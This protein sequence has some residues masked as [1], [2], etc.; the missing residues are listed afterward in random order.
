[1]LVHSA[2]AFDQIDLAHLDADS[3]RRVQATNVESALWL[4]QDFTPGMVERGFGRII[5]VISDT[6]WSPPGPEMLPYVASKGA[7][8]GVMRTL[9]VALGGHGIAVS[10]VAPGLTDTTAS[11][12][13]NTDSDFDAVVDRQALKRRLTP[14]DTASAVAYLASDGGAAMTGQILCVDAGLLMR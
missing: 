3:W 6:F 12:T 1:V 11:R 10:A 4:A 13:V 9:A 14:E 7:L 2:A 5:F 8:V